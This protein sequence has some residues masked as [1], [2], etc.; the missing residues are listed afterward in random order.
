MAPDFLKILIRRGHIDIE[1]KVLPVVGCKAG[2]FQP[3][4]PHFGVPKAFDNMHGVLNVR[5]APEHGKVRADSQQLVDQR[6]GGRDGTS[7]LD[8]HLEGA[9]HKPRDHA[10]VML[11]LANTF[12][13]EYQLEHISLIRGKAPIIGHYRGGGAIPCKDIPSHGPYNGGA[14]RHGI[15]QALEPRCHRVGPA[16]AH[17]WWPAE[18]DQKEVLALQC[19]QVQGLGDPVEDISRRVT[20]APL[21]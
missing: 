6:P 18:A 8:I 16:I 17:L 1:M 20:A 5:L 19:G 12:I 21:L 10:P 7:P 14:V 11:G 13:G 4:F 3:D 15:E 9:D 2:I